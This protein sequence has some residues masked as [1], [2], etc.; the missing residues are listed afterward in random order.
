MLNVFRKKLFFAATAVIVWAGIQPGI[1]SAQNSGV[2]ADGTMRLMWKATDSSI[3]LWKL[4]ASNS[5][6]F[7]SYHAYGPYYGWSPIALTTDNNGYSYVLWRYTDG[8]ISLWLVDPNLNFVTNRIYGPYTGWTAESL[9]V[10]TGG[11]GDR[12]RVIWRATDGS[13][14]IWIVDGGLNFVSNHVYGPYFGYTPSAGAATAAGK[15]STANSPNGETDRQA[16][17]AMGVFSGS[18]TPMPQK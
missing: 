15:L 13:V 18:A 6:N 1:L 14:S 5:I 3:S 10:E 2:G 4:D 7:L 9:S 11:S 16:A 17:A 8:S 12:F